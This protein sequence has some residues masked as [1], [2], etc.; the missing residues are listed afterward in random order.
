MSA[1]PSNLSPQAFQE[2]LDA[3]PNIVMPGS[4]HCGAVRFKVLHPPLDPQPT[5]QVPVSNCNCSI[6]QKNGYL[7]IYPNRKDVEWLSG[8]DEMKNYRFGSKNRDH[9]FCGVCGSSVCIDFLGNWHVGDVIGVNV[10]LLE[11][12]DL[13][14]LYLR[15]R[16]GKGN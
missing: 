11:G 8:W 16:N 4:C 12:V 1:N 2:A 9:K 15:K 7:T 6:C 3:L 14:K 10:R 13:E 5:C